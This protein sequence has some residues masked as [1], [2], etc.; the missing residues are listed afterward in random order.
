MQYVLAVSSLLTLAI[1]YLAGRYQAELLNKI[2]T[3][4]GQA[5]V[6]QVTPTVT[7]GVYDVPAPKTSPDAKRKVG[8]VEA[9]TPELLE[10]ER[11]QEIEKKALGH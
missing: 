6:E 10:W 11:Q 4:E 8:I 2:R 3:L 1:G 5:R 7:K 9:K